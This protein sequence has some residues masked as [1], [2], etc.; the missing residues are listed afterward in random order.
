MK[1]LHER[2]RQELWERQDLSRYQRIVVRIGRYAY[3]IARD[4]FDGQLNMRAMSLVYTTLLSLVPMLALAFSLFKALGVH[5]MLEPVLLRFL[6]PLGPQA[7]E[8]SASIVGFVEN[9][10]VGVLGSVG[11]GL[12]FYTAVSMIQKVESSFNF[13]WRVERVRPLSQRVGEYLAVLIVGPVLVFSSLGV[14]AAVFSSSVVAKL[15]EIEPLG[16]TI[17]LL[18][19]LVPYGLIIAAFTFVYAFIPN[20]KVRFGAALAGG[21]LAGAGWQYAS[22]LFAS[23]VAGSVNYNAIYSG[24]AIVILLLIWLYIGWLILLTGCQLAY[25]VQHPEHVVAHKDTPLLSART[26]EQLGLAVLMLA[27]RRFIAAEPALTEDEVARALDAHSEHA[28][29]VIEILLHQGLLAEV[30]AGGSARTALLPGRDLDSLTL[31]EAW[32]LIRRG[33]DTPHGASRGDASRR[34]A[35]L[36]DEI[37]A[38]FLKTDG[39]KTLR[40]WLAAE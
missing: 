9:I 3:V 14:T 30:S 37:E 19:K 15:A 10:R 2:L 12:L 6:E 11:V 20:T 28:S 13:I 7:A 22:V 33:L 32:Q 39:A 5:N 24:F 4:L 31:G 25:Y 21:A 26:A 40:Q 36:L 1:N 16:T 34:A 35:R 8:L 29:R 18:G 17:F 27:G 23:I 38:R